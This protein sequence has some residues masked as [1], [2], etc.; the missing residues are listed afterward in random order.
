MSKN[1]I[2]NNNEVVLNASDFIVSKTNSK[3]II[4]YCN[5]IFVTMADYTEEELIG[6]NHNIIRHPDM[7]KVAFKVAWDLI[8]SGKEFFGFVKNLRQNGGYYWVFTNITPDYDISGKI[9]GYTSI[10]RKPN[11]EA[12]KTI[13][14]LYKQLV[15]I[16]KTQGMNGSFDVIAALLKE[17]NLEYN[18]LIIALQG[19]Y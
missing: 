19:D 3:G 9:I 10:R 4:S 1:I 2:P 8:Q 17:K 5:Q 14:P 7:P 6:T 15:D 18:E 16:E 13:I 11:P 12:L